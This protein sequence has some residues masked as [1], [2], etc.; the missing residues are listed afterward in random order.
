MW[1]GL[2]IMEPMYSGALSFFPTNGQFG[3]SAPSQKES[4]GPFLTWKFKVSHFLVI[5]LFLTAK[6]LKWLVFGTL[7]ASE[8]DILR[9]KAGYTI[10]EFVFGF[11][12]FYCSTGGT[13]DTSGEVI[14]FAG[15]FLCVWLVKSFH[16]L[17]AARVQTLYSAP[18]APVLGDM[19]VRFLLWRVA[20]GIVM[21][22]VVDGLL[23]FKYMHDVMVTNYIKHNVLIT[24]FGFEIL[25]H[26]PLLMSTSLQFCL[27][28]NLLASEAWKRK[29][30]WIFFVAEFA[31]NLVLLA[32]SFIFSLLFFYH[33]TVPVYM[34]PAAYRSL[35]VAVTKTRVLI[36][37]RKRELMLGRLVDAASAG[38]EVCSICYEPLCV[39]QRNVRTTPC[40]D[41]GFHYGCIKLWLEYS[42]SCPFCRK[43]I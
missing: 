8:V 26:Y 37:F 27:N 36:E 5:G 29:R 41:R 35:K 14:K 33:Y 38:D 40:C 7:T 23:I 30:L 34:L 28:M 15:L 21:L 31:L 4:I 43:K 2:Q 10:W 16:Y 13:L 12:V 32:M 11:L 24:I 25:N 9:E 17:I 42:P 20:L 1:I 39:E 19:Q 6:F 18:D 3:F 22:N